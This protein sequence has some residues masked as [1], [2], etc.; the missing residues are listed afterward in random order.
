MAASEPA[1]PASR[2]LLKTGEYHLHTARQGAAAVARDHFIYIVGG[3]GH[4][5]VTDIERF[6]ARSH[7]LVRISDQLLPRRYHN[8]IEFQG[9]LFIFGGESIGPFD[10]PFVEQ[11]EIFDCAKGTFTLGAPMTYPG[12][13]MG[14]ARFGPLVYLFGGTRQK[15]NQVGQW[16]DTDIYDLA[17]NTWSK[18]PPMPLPRE[19]SAVAV[20]DFILVPGGFRAH[21]S[22]ASVDLLSPK[23]N[24][25][26]TLPRL[27]RPI[28][29]HATVFL[30][31]YL[32]LFGDDAKPG[33]V[34][35][36]DLSS[37]TTL[38]LATD[39]TGR[40]HAAAAVLDDTIYVIGGLTRAVD[41]QSDLIETFKL[42]PDYHP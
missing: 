1:P 20:G 21:R 16:S 26:R 37:R 3:D 23:E 33:S 15:S 42:N 7:Q 22:D 24:T 13:H 30:G 25:W 17:A 35:A 34:V 12:A 39:F 6:D 40:W 41:G 38:D 11:V 18:G 27:A 14:A 2:L 19:C 9:R 31:K 4:G 36:Y 10:F 32:F 29:E 5:P 8:V 28:S